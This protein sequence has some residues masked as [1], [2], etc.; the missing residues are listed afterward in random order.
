[1]RPS[2]PC[3]A[4]FGAAHLLSCGDAA[5]RGPTEIP[6]VAG[7]TALALGDSHTCVL[8]DDGTVRCLGEN[9]RG[10]LG[11]GTVD[12][13][14]KTTPVVVTDPGG[15]PLGGVRAIVGFANT[16]CART[17]E[18]TWSCWGADPLGI[19][20]KADAAPACNQGSCA[21]WAAHVAF[22]DGAHDVAIGSGLLLRNYVEGTTLN[23]EDS[24]D[25]AF[26]CGAFSDQVRCRTATRNG[27][28]SVAD[29]ATVIA[30]TGEAR[31]V[32]AEKGAFCI[33][34]TTSELRCNAITTPRIADEGSAEQPDP[35]RDRDRV[36]SIPD[37]LVNGA[38]IEGPQATDIAVG[39]QHACA[40][41]EDKTV[42]C[43]GL[44]FSG[45]AG[46][47]PIKLRSGEER[48]ERTPVRGLA[49]VASIALGG[50]F[51]C[52]LSERGAVSCWGNNS[53]GQLG[54]GSAITNA[55]PLRVDLPRP[56]SALAAGKLHACA[57]V[58]DEKKLVCWGS[59]SRVPL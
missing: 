44:S 58:G 41:N 46:V 37:E 49:D 8:G 24:I 14:R 59:R 11:G 3:L 48:I 45:E 34:M 30:L 54:G 18:T 33:L 4:I 15:A 23:P 19:L 32:V 35:R 52:A 22:L 13:G 27:A 6:G 50:A 51:S 53:A 42:D 25:Y 2:A 21:P 47:D 17:S 10:Q 28:Q 26:M 40:L 36:L 55:S 16:T 7:V 29:T 9:G 56:A 57:A 20:D 39:E 1:M 31:R 38:D 5:P 43:L 12:G